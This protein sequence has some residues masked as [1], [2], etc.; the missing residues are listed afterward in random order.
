MDFFNLYEQVASQRWTIAIATLI[1][2]V[3]YAWGIAPFRVLKNAFGDKVPGPTALPFIGN[4][5]DAIRHKGQMH[6]Q[7]EDYRKRYGDVFGMYLL[8]SVPC[9]VISDFDMI[10]QVY[11]KDFQAFH[12]RAPTKLRFPEPFNKMLNHAEGEDWRRIRNTLS[13][14][15]SAHKMK[16]MVPL[17][18]SACDTLMKRLEQVSKT[19]ESFDVIKY[20]QG[21]TM[22]VILLCAFGIQADSQ[23]NPNEPAIIAAKRAIN[24]SAPQR[25]ILTVL[26]LIPFGRK[27]IELFPS[28]LTRD[29]M[30]LMDISEQI[31]AAKNSTGSISPRK[32]GIWPLC[33]VVVTGDL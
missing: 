10:K 29:L 4:M 18:N 14:T 26:T 13:P 19:R 15:F 12:D 5:L 16:Q 33:Q 9:L 3:V 2:L 25:I 11:V 17:M 1:I 21:L 27:I 23:N 24:G 28:L 6:L 30:D 20:H 8:G 22:D 7:I 31:V 32:A